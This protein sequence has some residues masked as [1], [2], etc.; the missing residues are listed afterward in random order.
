MSLRS[1]LIA[2]G[3]AYALS[4][5]PVVL[6]QTATS[7]AASSAMSKADISKAKKQMRAED[8]ALSSAVRKSLIK[9]KG[10]DISRVT[11]LVKG[12]VVTL[13]GQVLKQESID[14]A[15]TAA[16]ATAGVTDVR[17]ELVVG[18]RGH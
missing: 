8:R 5:A 7:E 16:A 11:V 2:V 4:L 15:T 13:V 3:F 10:L 9:V 12:G 18:A 17:N 1:V 14:A 6:A